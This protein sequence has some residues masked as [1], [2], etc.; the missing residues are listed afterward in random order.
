MQKFHTYHCEAMRMGG[1]RSMP[2]YSR[3]PLGALHFGVSLE[4]QGSHIEN[5]S[6]TSTSALTAQEPAHS[7]SLLM[8]A[9]RADRPW[10]SSVA[11][12]RLMGS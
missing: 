5:I 1:L 7:A 11:R 3:Y 2:V 12:G 9:E 8:R 10:C 6:Y 4:A